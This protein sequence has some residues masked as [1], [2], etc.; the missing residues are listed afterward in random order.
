MLRNTSF[1]KRSD[2]LFSAC[3]ARQTRRCSRTTSK[4]TIV[5][6]QHLLPGRERSSP[7]PVDA[8]GHVLTSKVWVGPRR[9]L[10]HSQ[11]HRRPQP[12]RASRSQVVQN[13]AN[14]QLRIEKIQQ[15][16]RAS[17]RGGLRTGAPAGSRLLLQRRAV[18]TH[19]HSWVGPR[20]IKLGAVWNTTD[21]P[22][23]SR[24]ELCMPPKTHSRH[25]TSLRLRWSVSCGLWEGAG[26]RRGRTCHSARRAF[27]KTKH[28]QNQ[29]RGARWQDAN[30]THTR[31]P[32]P[33]V[34]PVNTIQSARRPHPRWCK[35][36]TRPNTRRPWEQCNTSWRREMQQVSFTQHTASSTQHT[37]C[38]RRPCSGLA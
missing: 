38:T 19:M 35:V 6:L 13:R 29:G 10:H 14:A 4:R 17:D 33:L 12:Y 7:T 25:P 30:V 21:S 31:P 37:L 23:R 34:L 28:Q 18:H 3:T 27:D 8:T 1:A 2:H 36:I 16:F 15:L 26:T 32:T 24:S 11:D 5:E 9:V 20:K 22:R